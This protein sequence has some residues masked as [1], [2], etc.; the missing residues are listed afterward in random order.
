MCREEKESARE[1]AAAKVLRDFGLPA[2]RAAAKAVALR[3]SLRGSGQAALQNS[4]EVENILWGNEYF[5]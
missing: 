4:L 3:R 5:S 2:G 1:C